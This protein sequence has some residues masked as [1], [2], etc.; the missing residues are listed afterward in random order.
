MGNIIKSIV[1]VLIASIVMG[2]VV[3]FINNLLGNITNIEM[4]NYLI[5]LVVSTTSGIIVYFILLL[6]LKLEDLKYYIK[7]GKNDE[8]C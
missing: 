4:L 6:V 8:K 7:V 3:Y 1:K 5:T 2:L